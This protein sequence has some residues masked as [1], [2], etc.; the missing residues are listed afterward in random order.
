V[1]QSLLVQNDETA[2]MKPDQLGLFDAMQ[3]SARH[4][5]YGARLRR[6]LPPRQATLR[7]STTGDL[8]EEQ[9]RQERADGAHKG[10]NRLLSWSDFT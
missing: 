8:S 4:Q 2:T 7:L 9:L 3:R 5:A 10:H 6:R 1:A